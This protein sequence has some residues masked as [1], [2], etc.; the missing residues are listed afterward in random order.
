MNVRIVDT[1]EEMFEYCR[2][3]LEFVD[4]SGEIIHTEECTKNKIPNDG[5]FVCT[6]GLDRIVNSIRTRLYEVNNT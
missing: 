1:S 2:E 5:F 4:P 6:C 3:I